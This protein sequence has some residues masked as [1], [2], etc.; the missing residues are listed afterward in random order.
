MIHAIAGDYYEYCRLSV[1]PFFYALTCLSI[2]STGYDKKIS[3]SDKKI[4]TN[5]DKNYKIDCLF[6]FEIFKK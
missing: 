5:F 2:V 4:F 3:Q 1:V 6:L